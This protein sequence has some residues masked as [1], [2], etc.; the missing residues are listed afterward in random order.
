MNAIARG[1]RKVFERPGV[2]AAFYM[3]ALTAVLVSMALGL[4]GEEDEE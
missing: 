4:G 2:A 1:T 3:T